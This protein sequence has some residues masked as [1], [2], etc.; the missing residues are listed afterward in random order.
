MPP[1]AARRP[2]R[3]EPP[4]ARAAEHRSRC[5][6]EPPVIVAPTAVDAKIPGTSRAG[7]GDEKSPGRSFLTAGADHCLNTVCARRDSN[8]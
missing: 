4:P 5:A 6:C 2:P 1:I 3:A 8:P 7:A